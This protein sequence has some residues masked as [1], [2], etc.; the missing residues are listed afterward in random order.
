M[1]LVKGI[2]V[3]FI[4]FANMANAHG[5]MTNSDGCHM[6]HSIGQFH[7]HQKKRNYY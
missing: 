1:R 4:L 3:F 7:C 6:N 2:S 5:G